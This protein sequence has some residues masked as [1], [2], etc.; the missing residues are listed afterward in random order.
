MA[1][2]QPSITVADLPGLEL[3]DT[4]GNAITVD[5]TAAGYGWT[6][7][8][9][10]DDTLRMDLLTVVRH[11]RTE[12]HDRH[13]VSSRSPPG[14]SPDRRMMTHRGSAAFESLS[15]RAWS[16]SGKHSAGERS[17]PLGSD[18]RSTQTHPLARFGIGRDQ[19]RR[20]SRRLPADTMENC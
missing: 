19:R 6:V 1:G 13:R 18:R 7:M 4:V 16:Y 2:V 12:A 20:A 3:G 5:A 11:T 17:N 8:H 10:G 14:T 15:V 9:Q